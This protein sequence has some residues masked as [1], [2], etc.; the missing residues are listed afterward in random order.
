MII[1]A[2]A[3]N[4]QELNREIRGSVTEE[5]MINNCLGQRYL[6]CG[7]SS[8]NIQIFG[9]PGNALGAYLDGAVIT[10]H[11]NA[12][13]SVGDTMN[14]GNILIHG[15]C[16]DTPG[17]AMRGGKIL[18]KENAGYRA[19]IHM[20]SYRDKLPVLVIGGTAGSFLGEYQA[21][22]RIIVLGLNSK[23]AC[24]VG[25]FCGTG[26][27]GGKIFLRCAELPTS[28][29]TQVHAKQAGKLDLLEIEKDIEEFCSEFGYKK[30]TVLD[31]PFYVLTPN[32]KNPYRQLYV[33]C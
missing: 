7:L 17:Y 25:Y 15:S 6:G 27:H 1:N 33:H 20:K 8:G 12:Q 30:E 3:M 23:Q 10:V 5:L 28:L 21:G 16:G 24:P 2:A 32:T 13:D 31:H 19:G 14:E 22:G 9:T 18:I 11:G 4:F 26:M 29:P